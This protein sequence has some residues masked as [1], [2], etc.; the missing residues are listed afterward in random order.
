[1]GGE[2]FN[3]RFGRLPARDAY[4]LWI[5][6]YT[7]YGEPTEVMQADGTWVPMEDGVDWPPTLRFDGRDVS[8]RGGDIVAAVMG[9]LAD[10]TPANA[11]ATEIKVLREAL[12]LERARVEKLVDAALGAG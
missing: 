2:T 11:A 4:G 12:A 3:A 6:R 5:Y 7:R 1:M 10:E 9:A 8:R